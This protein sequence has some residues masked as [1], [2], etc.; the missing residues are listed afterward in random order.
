MD[1]GTREGVLQ[2][3]NALEKNRT[4]GAEMMEYLGLWVI[5]LAITN[6]I[7]FIFGYDLT[8]KNKIL[9]VLFIQTCFSLMEVGFVLLS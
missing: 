4:K 8:I 1:Y 6:I 5:A 7:T 9:L 2:V 3:H